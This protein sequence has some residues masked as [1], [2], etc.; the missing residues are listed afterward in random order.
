MDHT[1]H[2]FS[3]PEWDGKKHHYELTKKVLQGTDIQVCRLFNGLFL[4]SGIGPWYGFHTSKDVYQVVGSVDQSNSYTDISDIARVVC[5]LAQKAM[6]GE[7]VP[8]KLRIGGS[9]AS[10]RQVAQAM[11]EAGAGDIELRSVNLEEFRSKALGRDYQD[12]GP[13]VCLRFLMGDGRI[14]YRPQID[15][16]LG[17]DNELVNPGQKQFIWKSISDLAA[18]TK[19]RPNANA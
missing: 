7:Q 12:R 3:I 14:D 11:T 8:A 18:E 1:L 2:D 6:S 9:Q 4:H 15:G 13:I 16:G 17:N 10:V 19:G 5:I